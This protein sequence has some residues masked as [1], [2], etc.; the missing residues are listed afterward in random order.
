M[1]EVAHDDGDVLAGPTRE[2]QFVDMLHELTL[3]AVAHRV[4]SAGRIEVDQPF[5]LREM[6]VRTLESQ[7][8]GSSSSGCHGLTT[9][10]RC[11]RHGRTAQEVTIQIPTTT[12]EDT[13]DHD[14]FIVRML[15]SERLGRWSRAQEDRTSLA[16]RH[17]AAVTCTLS[18]FRG[19][20]GGS[21]PDP[22][23]DAP[24]PAIL[25]WPGGL[26]HALAG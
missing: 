8:N 14:A 3:D 4:W 13:F 24:P 1:K 6:E 22:P 23:P 26:A 17:N 16:D 21:H 15:P 20:R 12:V 18:A 10:A 2:L 9:V 25:A 19:E 11:D 7:L 5:E